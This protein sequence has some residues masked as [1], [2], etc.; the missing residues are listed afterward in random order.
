MM[1][2]YP[3]LSSGYINTE[4]PCAT[5]TTQKFTVRLLVS[6]FIFALYVVVM[7]CEVGTY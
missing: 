2:E 3:V 4:P 6:S 5:A 1:R 7:P